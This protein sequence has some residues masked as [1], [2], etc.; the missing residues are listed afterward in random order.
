M[1]GAHP[2]GPPYQRVMVVVESRVVV[3]VGGA[4]LVVLL[5]LSSATPLLLR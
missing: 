1:R 5:T 4:N 3:S 2:V